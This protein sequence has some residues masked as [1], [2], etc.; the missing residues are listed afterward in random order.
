[1][2]RSSKQKVERAAIDSDPRYLAFM[3]RY[4]ANIYGFA[5]EVCGMD[6]T[7]Q[8]KEL[9]DETSIFGA[10]V[11]VASGHGTGKTRS[12]G[13]IGFWHLFCY[14]NSNTYITAPKLKTDRKSVV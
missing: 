8:Q 10:R 2:A 9:F 3:E 4:A 11:S 5:V 7:H 6:V 13:V 14:P 1:M 12:F